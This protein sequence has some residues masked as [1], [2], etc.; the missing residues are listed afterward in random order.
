[1]AFEIISSWHLKIAIWLIN[2]NKT[3]L[4]QHICTCA[5]LL[6]R[7]HG[8]PGKNTRVGCHALLQGIFPTQGLNLCLLNL[9][10]WQEDSLPSEPQGKP[11]WYLTF[12]LFLPKWALYLSLW[13]LFPKPVIICSQL[14]TPVHPFLYVSTYL[15][16]MK[17]ETLLL[18]FFWWRKIKQILPTPYLLP[19]L[20]GKGLKT[21]PVLDWF[22]RS[23]FVG[24]VIG[25]GIW[26]GISPH[27]PKQG[28]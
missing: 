2:P 26:M 13:C 28:A 16:S 25:K 8:A 14:F 12:G 21:L 17:L 3:K 11:C 19:S 10:H 5:Q 4:K 7:P 23:R 18:Y 20:H 22:V 1:M 24:T 27:T 6:L 9:L 15:I